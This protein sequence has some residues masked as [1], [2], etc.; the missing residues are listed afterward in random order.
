M[1]NKLKPNLSF[2]FEN[3][4]RKK[5]RILDDSR[6]NLVQYHFLGMSEEKKNEHIAAMNFTFK[7]PHSNVAVVEKP[8]KGSKLSNTKDMN[9]IDSN[10]FSNN[11][12]LFGLNKYTKDAKITNMKADLNSSQI[13]QTLKMKV[14]SPF[15]RFTKT[16]NHESK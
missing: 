11:N 14:V 12:H 2:G 6:G 13:N 1:I 9:F 7:E 5:K 15:D 4:F 3:T 16:R 8:S 10:I